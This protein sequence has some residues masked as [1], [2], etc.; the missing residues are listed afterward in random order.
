[1]EGLLWQARMLEMCKVDAARTVARQ[2]LLVTQCRPSF[3]ASKNCRG[4]RFSASVRPQRLS[5]SARGWFVCLKAGKEDQWQRAIILARFQGVGLYTFSTTPQRAPLSTTPTTPL[6][7]Q[8][9]SL[10]AGQACVRWWRWRSATKLPSRWTSAFSATPRAP[11]AGAP[12]GCAPAP[13]ACPPNHCSLTDCALTGIGDN[14]LYIAG[15]LPKI[16]G[17]LTP[18]ETRSLLTYCILPYC[19]IT[20]RSLRHR[21]RWRRI[22][23]QLADPHGGESGGPG[24]TT[25]QWVTRRRPPPRPQRSYHRRPSSSRP[26]PPPERTSLHWAWTYRGPLVRW[27]WSSMSLRG[28][29]LP[30]PSAGYTASRS[31]CVI[32]PASASLGLTPLPPSPPSPLALPPLLPPLFLPSP[33]PHSCMRDVGVTA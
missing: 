12:S 14:A 23:T 16:L 18:R 6:P 9:H 30:C 19:P 33:V 10:G 1:M 21:H 32:R 4:I 7:H 26:L 11:S 2:T 24:P 28:R 3:A 15:R 29:C 17:I 22:R 13:S 31:V 5:S 8:T 20:H 25:T 27:S